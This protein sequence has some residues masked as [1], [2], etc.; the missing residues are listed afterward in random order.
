MRDVLNNC[1]IFG[2]GGCLQCSDRYLL[3]GSECISGV[4]INLLYQLLPSNYS[5]NKIA[6]TTL[7]MCLNLKNQFNLN[8]SQ[9]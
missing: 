9:C 4:N 5:L 6:Y 2:L 3:N 1:I 8:N 7:N